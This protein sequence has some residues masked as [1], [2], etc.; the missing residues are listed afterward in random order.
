MKKSVKNTSSLIKQGVALEKLG[1]YE[2]A[3][4]YLAQASK[5]VKKEIPKSFQKNSKK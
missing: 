2:E 5:L 1:K 3:K 4:K